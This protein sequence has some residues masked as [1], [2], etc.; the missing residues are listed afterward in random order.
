MVIDGDLVGQSTMVPCNQPS[1]HELNT[2]APYW[3][4]RMC[5][6]MFINTHWNT[7]SWGSQKKA[8]DP[9]NSK[10]VDLSLSAHNF[11][12]LPVSFVV[13]KSFLTPTKEN[14]S[15]CWL[16][17]E[18]WNQIPQ[19]PLELHFFLSPLESHHHHCKSHW[20]QTW[21]PKPLKSQSNPTCI[22]SQSHLTVCKSSPN[23]AL[24]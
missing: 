13:S 17:P 23:H 19:N 6:T 3:N 11:L 21:N 15:G 18:K 12:Q 24:T 2:A 8:I 14:L 7:P 1:G 20:N 10:L 9:I 22:P 16:G 4:L 5:P